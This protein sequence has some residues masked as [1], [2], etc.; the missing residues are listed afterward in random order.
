MNMQYMCNQICRNDVRE[1]KFKF[2]YF[3]WLMVSGSK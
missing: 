1:L 2:N 3:R